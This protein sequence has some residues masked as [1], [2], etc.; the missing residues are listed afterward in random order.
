M[1]DLVTYKCPKCG[2]TTRQRPGLTIGCA[3][4]DATREKP[5]WHPLATMRKVTK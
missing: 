1:T 3:G 2:R 4:S 5:G